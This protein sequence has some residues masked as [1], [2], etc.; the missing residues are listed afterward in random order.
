MKDNQ[1]RPLS[2]VCND[3]SV[4]VVRIEAGKGLVSRLTSLG[5]IP[6]T[7]LTVI[8]NGHPGPFVIEVKK[9]RIILG[10]GMANK[11]IVT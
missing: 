10:K 9:S 11:I 4:T 1:T 2:T 7:P 8:N 6:K 3:E 5:V